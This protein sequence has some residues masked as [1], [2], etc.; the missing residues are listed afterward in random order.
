MMSLMLEASVVQR[1]GGA[2][3]RHSNHAAPA[4]DSSGSASRY[5]WPGWCHDGMTGVWLRSAIGQGMALTSR[6]ANWFS[7]QAAPAFSGTDRLR[8]RDRCGC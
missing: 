8:R 1:V 4:S 2:A 6:A 7:Q 3:V 5:C